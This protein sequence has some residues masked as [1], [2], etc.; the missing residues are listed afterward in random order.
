MFIKKYKITS[1]FI[2]ENEFETT[3]IRKTTT[4]LTT[5]TVTDDEGNLISSSSVLPPSVNTYITEEIT[6]VSLPSRTPADVEI[7]ERID[8]QNEDKPEKE[9][10]ISGPKKED[11]P[12]IMTGPSRPK[13]IT[14]DQLQK[15]RGISKSVKVEFDRDN[16][17]WVN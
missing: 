12:K 13:P 1:K 14:L 5:K 17:K 7:I 9:E 6:A 15:D 16:T 4:V 3:K 10:H 11:G 8:D 2:E